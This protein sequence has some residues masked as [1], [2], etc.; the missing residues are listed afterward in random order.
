MF[1]IG[2]LIEQEEYHQKRLSLCLRIFKRVLDV[3]KN[4][5]LIVCGIID[6]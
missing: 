3:N 4:S 6:D 2:G 5:K 1:F